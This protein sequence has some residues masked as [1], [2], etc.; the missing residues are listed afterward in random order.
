MSKKEST[1]GNMVLSLTLIATGFALCLGIVH[2]VTAGPIAQTQLNKKINA[3]SEV[4]PSFDN[5]PNSEMYTASTPEGDYDLEIYPAKQGDEIVG[6]AV[7]TLSMKGFSGEIDMMVGFKPDGEIYKIS[8]LSH[9]ETPGLGA[10][11]NTPE[12]KDQFNSKN[13][14]SYKLLVKKDGGDVDAITA[15]TI[16]SRAF[17]DAVQRAYDTLFQNKSIDAASGETNVPNNTSID[18]AS[19]ETSV[20]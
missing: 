4:V 6:Y 13:P 3:I 16:S 8:V 11:M 14:S 9:S 10:K 18:A 1:F 20:Q 12:F 15:A 7:K 5:D 2:E 19:G 17:S